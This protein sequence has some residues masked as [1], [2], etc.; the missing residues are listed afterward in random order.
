MDRTRY[1]RR[2]AGI[3]PRHTLAAILV[4]R[5]V[6][7][8]ALCALEQVVPARLMRVREIELAILGVE[9]R[10]WP[11]LDDERR[12]SVVSLHSSWF[13]VWSPVLRR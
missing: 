1:T 9:I 5:D 11:V 13:P 12:P 3:L 2:S 10:V 4:V 8:V 7:E 6:V